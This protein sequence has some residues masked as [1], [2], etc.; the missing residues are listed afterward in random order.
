ME[1]LKS[2]SGNNNNFK[3]TFACLYQLSLVTRLTLHQD[4]RQEGLIRFPPELI[5]YGVFVN[6]R[7]GG[8]HPGA[9]CDQQYVKVC[10]KEGN[11]SSSLTSTG[12]S[13]TRHIN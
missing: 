7:G 4:G 1:V 12:L 2:I 6:R 11:Q 5:T 8:G 9:S 13:L 3:L 10:L